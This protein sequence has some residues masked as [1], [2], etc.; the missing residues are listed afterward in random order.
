[1]AEARFLGTL[2]HLR[3]FNMLSSNVAR[4]ERAFPPPHKLQILNTSEARTTT[5][6]RRASEREDRRMARFGATNFRWGDG[7]GVPC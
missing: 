4:G 7:I 6:S 2:A 5:G 3:P 1:M